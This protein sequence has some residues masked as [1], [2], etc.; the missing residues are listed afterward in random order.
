MG[1]E[2]EEVADDD[3]RIS[4]SGP[5]VDSGININN[6]L[7]RTPRGHLNLTLIGPA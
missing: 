5:D 4:S 1:E 2:E 3:L 7:S 6:L